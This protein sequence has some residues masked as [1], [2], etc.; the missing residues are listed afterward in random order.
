MR[1]GLVAAA[2]ACLACSAPPPPNRIDQIRAFVEA[3]GNE[4]AS[5]L[6]LRAL[7]VEA[8]EAPCEGKFAEILHR[9]SAAGQEADCRF[10]IDGPFAEAVLVS[11]SALGDLPEIRGLLD[12]EAVE[13]Y[14][15]WSERPERVG[16]NRIE[17]DG[18]PGIEIDADA[19]E[20]DLILVRVPFAE[21]WTVDGP[22]RLERDPIGYVLLRPEQ[23]GRQTFRLR[24]AAAAPTTATAKAPEWTIVEYPRI[25]PEGV[26]QPGQRYLVV[27]GEN[28]TPGMTNALIDGRRIEAVFSSE[29]QLNFRLPADVAP[30]SHEFQVETPV[31]RSHAL[32][33]EVQAEAR[34]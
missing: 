7:G 12:L 28:F 31:G 19:A 26:V 17:E 18:E 29:T 32:T 13:A 27:Y 9:Q 1:I 24:R 6:W 16:L 2:L 4:Q 15:L 23:T 33:I 11:R 21:G 22:A 20:N 25:H 30:G 14:V 10:T 3:P 5:V 34:P 8:L